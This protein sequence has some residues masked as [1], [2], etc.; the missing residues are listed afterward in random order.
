MMLE[1]IENLI[2]D[3]E[4]EFE[5]VRLVIVPMENKA[6]LKINREKPIFFDSVEEAKSRAQLILDRRP[7]E[8]PVVKKSKKKKSR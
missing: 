3:L 8:A 7:K 4:A 6:Q 1:W 5:G 2:G